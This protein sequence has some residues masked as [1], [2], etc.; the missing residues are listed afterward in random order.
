MEKYYLWTSGTS[1]VDFLKQLALYWTA[2]VQGK[3]SDGIVGKCPASSLLLR[4]SRNKAPFW[5]L[6]NQIISDS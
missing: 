3:E 6:A 2:V 1:D 4:L 5:L